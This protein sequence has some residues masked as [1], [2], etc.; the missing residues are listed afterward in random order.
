MAKDKATIPDQIRVH[1]KISANYRELHIDGAF[2]GITTRGYINL[3]FYAERLPIP[4]ATD[5]S[6]TSEGKMGDKIADSEDSKQGLLREFE[7]GVYM[8]ITTAKSLVEFL[9]VK[10][11]ELEKA[12]IFINDKSIP[13]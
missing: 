9:N 4:K 7:F 2:G 3:S 5:F 6:I 12:L 8:D 13:K 10:I 1:N 11:T